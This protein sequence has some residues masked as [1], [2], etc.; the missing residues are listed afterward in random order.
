MVTSR[1]ASDITVRVP[2]KLNLFF[3]VLG[4]RSDGF[5]EIET[6]MAPIDLCDELLFQVAPTGVLSVECEW[7]TANIRGTN[8]GL[9]TLPHWEANLATH[10][11]RRLQD[12]AGVSRGARIRL[13]KRIPS[14]AGLGGGSADAAATLLAANRGWNL[15]W[16]LDRLA[17]VAAEL[18]SDVPYF[19][20]GNSAICSGRGE[21][22]T[23][24]SGLSALHA[25]VVRPPEGLSTADVYR[26]CRLSETPK[27]IGQTIS[28]FER[29]DLR[30]LGRY[31]TNRLQP[32]A[33][34]LSPWIERVIT[35]FHRFGCVAAQMTGSGTSCFGICHSRRQARRVAA[36]VRSRME[37]R[38]FVVRIGALA[39]SSQGAK[40][41]C[42]GNH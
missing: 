21:R 33:E 16:P 2:A 19:L 26:N 29:G 7:A 14:A 10:A 12:V 38:V 11:V 42:R 15:N 31:L 5:H 28:A 32:S 27:P 3:E 25:V 18:G 39:D 34:Q 30:N 41:H 37:G 8:D 35:E 17:E 20:Y 24:I 13:I 36:G 6:L 23:P 4:K 22:V 9:G 40:E 1:E